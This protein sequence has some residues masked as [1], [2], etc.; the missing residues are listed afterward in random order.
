[1]V[2]AL[3]LAG[4]GSTVQMRSTA[5]IGSGGTG[6]LVSSDG[7]QPAAGGTTRLG[8][9]NSSTSPVTGGS[10]SGTSTGSPRTVQ[11]LSP[12]M[13]GASGSAVHRRTVTIGAWVAGSGFD[14]VAANMGINGLAIGNQTNQVQALVKDLN[15]HGGL[16]G[17]KIDLVLHVVNTTDTGSQST[18]AQAACADF[19]EDH[20]V[21]FVISGLG[22]PTGLLAKCLAARGV[23]LINDDYSVDSGYLSSVS[24]HLFLPSGWSMDRLMR[25]QIDALHD[26]GFFKGEGKVG[27]LLYDTPPSQKVLRQVVIPRL[28]AIG[29]AAP[30]TYA[31][32][33]DGSDYEAESSG[34]LKFRADGVTRIITIECSP[35]GFMLNAESQN[36]NPR[37]AVYSTDGPGALLETAAPKNQLKG[38][39]GFGWS[40]P[41]DVN[42]AHQPAPVSANQTRCWTLMK[43]AGEDT[44]GTAGALQLW[45]CDAF[46]F[47]QRALDTAGDVSA[48]ALAVG[49]RSM[50]GYQSPV[51]WRTDLSSGR[52]DGVSAYRDLAYNTGCSCYLYTSGLKPASA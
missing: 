5:L 18:Q 45:F 6:G 31:L 14:T 36:Y 37:Y 52:P 43:N 50:R 51:T 20:H 11:P 44:S 9:A 29:V 13:V 33:A 42:G 19:T 4:C 17:A 22:D 28:A 10:T 1:V 34:V 15:A 49:A 32:K 3:V 23:P 41:Y 24:G 26:M 25:T 48:P 40:P 2:L 38:S 47:L 27:I 30:D 46:W 12:S 21:Q 35:L 7:T 8:G 39:V 16:L